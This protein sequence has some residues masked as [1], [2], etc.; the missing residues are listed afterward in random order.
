MTK[1]S[2]KVTHLECHKNVPGANEADYDILQTKFSDVISMKFIPKGRIDSK[3][4]LVQV[5][6]G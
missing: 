4:A 6:G 3:P 1:I 5:L 2:I